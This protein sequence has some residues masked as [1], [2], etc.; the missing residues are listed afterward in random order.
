MQCASTFHCESTISV[1][2]NT[3]LASLYKSKNLD[4]FSTEYHWQWSLESGICGPRRALESPRA[5]RGTFLIVQRYRREAL[6]SSRSERVASRRCPSSPR[7]L[8]GS[9]LFWNQPGMQVRHAR[10]RVA[11]TWRLVCRAASAACAA[12][13]R[14]IGARYTARR[15]ECNV[16]R[17]GYDRRK[18]AVCD[19]IA[20]PARQVLRAENRGKSYKVCVV[21]VCKE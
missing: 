2:R 20:V 12:L 17:P 13:A 1:R 15:L 10:Q 11:Q 3:S 5:G 7:F 16:E 18:N 6:A 19:D 9:C 4:P 8:H 21:G 14:Q